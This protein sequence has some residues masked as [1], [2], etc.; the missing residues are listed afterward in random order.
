MEVLVFT[1]KELRD[2]DGPNLKHRVARLVSRRYESQVGLVCMV[3]SATFFLLT[4]ARGQIEANVGAFKAKIASETLEIPA[5]RDLISLCS[6]HRR[7][8]HVFI[9]LIDAQHSY[10]VYVADC[11]YL[12]PGLANLQL[13]HTAFV[14]EDSWDN[15]DEPAPED[16]RDDDDNDNDNA[17]VQI[18]AFRLVIPTGT[19]P[20]DPAQAYSVDIDLARL[21]RIINALFT[22]MPALEGGGGSRPG[23]GVS[24]YESEPS[25]G[26]VT[27]MEE[28]Q[29]LVVLVYSI[30]AD[31]DAVKLFAGKFKQFLL[32]C[33]AVDPTF[34]GRMVAANPFYTSC[35]TMTRLARMSEEVILSLASLAYAKVY[36][37]LPMPFHHLYLLLEGESK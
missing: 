26:P 32:D 30:C 20:P 36:Y 11:G 18:P 5:S 13:R 21:S 33:G 2:Q 31:R 4:M 35:T 15:P 19:D 9:Y 23:E 14:T 12:A 24:I 1:T 8:L 3:D 6:E 25:L 28:Q 37:S 29:A 22:M 7:N 17:Q 16:L 10:R 34:F 27:P